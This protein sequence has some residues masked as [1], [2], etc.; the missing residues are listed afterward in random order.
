MVEC[1]KTSLF[2]FFIFKS[3]VKIVGTFIVEYYSYTSFIFT[4]S[5]HTR[6]VLIFLVAKSQ[7]L[8]QRTITEVKKKLPLKYIFFF[9]LLKKNKL[10]ITA[11]SLNY[12]RFSHFVLI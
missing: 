5:C 3:L 1:I 6:N 8:S 10:L 9:N 2:F 11:N 4:R 7:K 12:I